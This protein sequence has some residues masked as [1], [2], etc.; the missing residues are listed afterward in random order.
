MRYSDA[1]LN[2]ISGIASDWEERNVES[3]RIFGTAPAYLGSEKLLTTLARHTCHPNGISGV[4]DEKP[5]FGQ[6]YHT[7]FPSQLPSLLGT[8]D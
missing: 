6:T 7:M 8:D 1:D 4:H 5:Y 3:V 2:G